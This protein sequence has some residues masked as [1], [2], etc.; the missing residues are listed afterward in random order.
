MQE[1]TLTLTLYGEEFLSEDQDWSRIRCK[2]SGPVGIEVYHVIKEERGFLFLN[3]NQGGFN[4]YHHTL[5]DLV[6]NA[7]LRSNTKVF[8]V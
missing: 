4:G 5:K 1:I 7:L 8:V 3:P 2:N 6:I